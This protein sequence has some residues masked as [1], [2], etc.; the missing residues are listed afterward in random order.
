MEEAGATAAYNIFF[1]AGS[2]Y[3]DLACKTQFIVPSTGIP[4]YP[5]AESEDS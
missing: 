5:V 3:A 1:E 4:Q 2:G